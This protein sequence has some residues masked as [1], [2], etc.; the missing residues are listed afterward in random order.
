MYRPNNP[1]FNVP[2]GANRGQHFGPGHSGRAPEDFRKN[3]PPPHVQNKDAGKSNQPQAPNLPPALK[4]TLGPE[5]NK[6][7]S[8][9]TTVNEDDEGTKSS[10]DKRGS[11][12]RS[13]PRSHLYDPYEPIKS[14]SDDHPFPE[15]P[16]ESKKSRSRWDIDARQRASEKRA[17][18]N[19]ASENRASEN[20]ASENRATEHRA[21]EHRATEHRP[22]IATTVPL[23]PP[24][25]PPPLLPHQ[26]Q[27]PLLLPPPL[28]PPHHLPPHH[29]PPH[30]LPPHHLPPHQLP[31]HQLPPHQLPP[32]QLPPHQQ[33][34]HQLPPQQQ[35][36]Q[37]QPPQ[38]QPPQQL[39]PQQLPPQQLPPQ[40]L[41]PPQL[42]SERDYKQSSGF[43]G[44]DP[45]PPPRPEVNDT[46]KNELLTD[47]NLISC[48][49]CEVEVSNGQE[50]EEHLDS[51]THWDTLEFIQKHNNYD[52]MVIAFL[53]DVMLYKSRKCSRAIEDTALQAL[54]DY[55][56]MTKVEMFHCA[57][58]N[59]FVPTC[60]SAVQ[61]HITTQGHITNTKKFKDRQRR[62]C[63]NKASTMMKE[64]TPQFQSFV[65]GLSPFE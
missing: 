35:P 30:H 16:E 23:S 34:P 51:K 49:L 17:S 10:C 33:P 14:D 20:R 43:S 25:Q 27:P 41:P 38:Q 54:Q 1:R 45:L 55:D 37:Q 26:Q 58:C 32:H 40:Q 11:P 24:P 13:R 5:I 64:L 6:W 56:H 28:L 42:L 12:D 21:T 29:L 53:Q 63:V 57:A 60:A 31:P 46:D 50:L 4:K 62:L 22:E 18:E 65:K 44:P 47:N 9:F 59:A 48:D 19:R 15:P 2:P 36:P 3:V 52:D 61:N 7:K 8:S 39:P